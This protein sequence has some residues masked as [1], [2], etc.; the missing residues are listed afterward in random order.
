MKKSIKLKF[1]PLKTLLQLFT[2]QDKMEL[3]DLGDTWHPS[4]G[5]VDE[6]VVGEVKVVKDLLNYDYEFSG[7]V[8][9]HASINDLN[10]KLSNE[11]YLIEGEAKSVYGLLTAIENYN[12]DPNKEEEIELL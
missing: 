7:L 8:A 5:F 4:I 3:Y 10:V 6:A 1:I 9:L 12:A 11:G 2:P